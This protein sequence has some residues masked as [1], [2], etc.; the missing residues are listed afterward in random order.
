MAAVQFGQNMGQEIGSQRRDDPEPDHPVEQRLVL[1]GEIDD[2]FDLAQDDA[3]LGDDLP[4]DRRE[5]H[6]GAATL[7]QLDPEALLQLANLAAHGGLGHVDRLGGPA[8]MKLVG[9]RHQEA[10]VLDRQHGGNRVGARG[11]R[12][13]VSPQHTKPGPRLPGFPVLSGKPIKSGAKSNF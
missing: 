10:E 13:S 9:Q 12:L 6:L 11:H 1:L 8:E 3:R 4:P 5:D 2:G 7:H